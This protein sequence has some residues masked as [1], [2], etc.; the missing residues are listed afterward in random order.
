[1]NAFRRQAGTGDRAVLR[2]SAASTLGPG[3]STGA[4]RDEAGRTS[5]GVTPLDP[6]PSSCSIPNVDDSARAE[7]YGLRPAV[8]IRD[9]GGWC[10]RTARIVATAEESRDG[11]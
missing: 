5:G 8:V 3:T 11:E 10:S 4:G 6:G 2:G 1:M 9:S 7:G